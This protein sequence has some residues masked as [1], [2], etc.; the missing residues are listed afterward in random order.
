[1]ARD[2]RRR[3]QTNVLLDPVE[4]CLDSCYDISDGAH[5]MPGDY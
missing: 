3:G 2:R 4:P 5:N 1:M